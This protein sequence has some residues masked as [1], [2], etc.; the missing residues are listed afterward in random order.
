M[1]FFLMSILSLCSS[2]SGQINLIS[3][4]SFS[5]TSFWGLG[6]YNGAI[7]SGST[8][9]GQYH[10][11]ITES[12]PEAW[13][14]QLTQNKIRVDS[15]AVY[16]FSFEAAANLPRTIEAS[17]S[18]DGGD[19]Q[20]YS[21]RDTLDL[22]PI[23]Q[24]FE[25]TFIMRH[26][27]D[28]SARV[29]FNCGTS[30]G[31]VSIS[32]VELVQQPGPYLT[33]QKPEPGAILYDGYPATISWVSAGNDAALRIELSTDNGLN[34]EEICG[35]TPDTGSF[36]WTPTPHYSP[37]CLLRI[38]STSDQN[39]ISFTTGPFEIAPRTEL[40]RNGDFSDGDSEWNLGKYGGSSSGSVTE[41]GMFHLQIDSAGNEKWH[42]QFSQPG[43]YLQTGV[44]YV[45]SFS[46]YAE[47]SQT[48]NVEVNMN[49]G[50]YD[51]YIDSS[52]TRHTLTT[53]PQVFQVEFTMIKD[54]DPDARLE[55]NCGLN[56]GSIYID[57]ISLCKKYTTGSTSVFKVVHPS[58]RISKF[59]SLSDSKPDV[60]THCNFFEKRTLVDL[61]G[62]LIKNSR[63]KPFSMVN[64]APGIYISPDAGLQ[65]R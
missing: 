55:F 15:G 25:Y 10:I 52:K 41:D 7:A 60:F 45:L 37:W 24:R 46:A 42:I 20:S 35:S 56:T 61:K 21:G 22:S 2:L 16:R 31:T 6:L 39:L 3:N 59:L 58:Q 27:S 33:L 32:N 47:H 26:P 57:N 62:R 53:E 44:T 49:G 12:A 23:G 29:E 28:S 63:S 30:E 1:R 17:I 14:V 51:N 9:S 64:K 50:S 65:N 48:I 43:I 5:D 19:Y 36:I 4:G 18:R 34:W 8:S 38:V 13:S 54:N 11:T 40:I